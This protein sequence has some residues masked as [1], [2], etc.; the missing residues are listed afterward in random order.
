M[1]MPAASPTPEV[2]LE[3]E[4]LVGWRVWKL[5]RTALGDLR[6]RAIAPSHQ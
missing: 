3:I 6:L 4:P 5:Q 2:P 1:S